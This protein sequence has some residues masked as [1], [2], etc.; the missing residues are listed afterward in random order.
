[1]ARVNHKLVKKLMNEKRSKITDRSFFTSRLLAAHFEDVA[2]AQT[3]RY[4]YNREIRVDLTWNT[5]CEELAHTDNQVIYI[6]VGNRH[7]TKNRG[8]EKRYQ[9]VCGTFAHELGHVLFTDFLASQTYC[10]A[11]ENGRWF[12]SAPL[13]KTKKDIENEKAIWEY[14]KKAPDNK[15]LFLIMVHE[16]SNILEDGYIEQQMLTKFPGTLGY[17]LSKWRE[18]NRKN[19]P[20]VTQLIEYEEDQGHIYRSICQLI[21]SYSL[22]GEIKYGDEPLTDERI[23]VVF[24]LLDVIDSAIFSKSARE[25]FLAVSTIVVRLWKYLEDYME[26]VKESGSDS[27]TP[28]RGASTVAKGSSSSV[29]G[30]SEDDESLSDDETVSVPTGTSRART[31]QTASMVVEDTEEQEDIGA[32]KETE[33]QEETGAQEETEAQEEAWSFEEKENPFSGSGEEDEQSSK[34]GEEEAELSGMELEEDETFPEEHEAD[35]EDPFSSMRNPKQQG[36]QKQEVSSNEQ[37]RLPNEKTTKASNPT[38]GSVT[39]N[40]N[41]ERECYE[42]AASD[43]D[44][45]LEQMAEKEACKEL[46]NE[47][48]KE[49]N[50]VA[51]SISYGNIHDGV[52]VHVNRITSVDDMLVDQYNLVADKLLTIS[53]QLARELVKQLQESRRGGKMTGLLMGRRMDTYAICRNDGKVF[54]KTTLPNDTPQLAVGLLLDESGS[55]SSCD[56]S[57]YAR[58]TA[59]ILHD[60]CEKLDIPIMIYGHS[61]GYCSSGSSVEMYSYAEFEGFDTDDRY[62]LMDISARDGNRDGAALR[63][64]AEQLVKRP[65]EV[66]LLIIVSDGQPADSGYYGS[67]AEEDLRGIRQEYIK[68]GVLFVAAAIG[69]DKVNIERIY[70]DSFMDIS[71]LNQLP[72]K[73]TGAIKRHIRL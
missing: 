19:M 45:L 53:R 63:F 29:L 37:G 62:R 47:R 58:A 24:G 21:L 50:E 13:L 42:R 71:D 5:K 10:N 61:T 68:K 25:R 60:F 27:S 35:M 22:Y 26:Q 46:E 6:N 30:N 54:C 12:P 32:Q 15:N 67:A 66:K 44:R 2:R 41:Y 23:Q 65:E 69:D 16:I 36:N 34:G 56:R 40:E 57:T 3:K 20:T 48:L 52:C 1:M 33:I 38:G 14:V 31:K 9:I 4:G 49:L 43:I 55:M 17:S 28:L 39:K 51:K 8:R 59:I 73:L 7:I 70:G 18:Q 11:I 72:N 64:V